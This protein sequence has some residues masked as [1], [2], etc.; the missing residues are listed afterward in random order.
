MVLFF[1]KKSTY[2]AVI[3]MQHTL[4]LRL[5]IVTLHTNNNYS[6]SEVSWCTKLIQTVRVSKAHYLTKYCVDSKL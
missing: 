5:N 2:K 6:M 4:Y 1:N 3:Q